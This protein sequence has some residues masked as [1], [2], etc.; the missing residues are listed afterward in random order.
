V[1]MIS[2]AKFCPPCDFSSVDT[3]RKKQR[4]NIEV[5]AVSAN[6]RQGPRS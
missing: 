3:S 5:S 1:K 4:N 6:Q 2:P